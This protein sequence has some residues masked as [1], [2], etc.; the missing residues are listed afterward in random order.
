MWFITISFHPKKTAFP[1]LR[2]LYNHH[3]HAGYF[4]ALWTHLCSQLIHFLSYECHYLHFGI[5]LHSTYNPSTTPNIC[6]HTHTHT[7]TLAHPYTHTSHKH[8]YPHPSASSRFQSNPN[9][10]PLPPL[11]R[12][13]LMHPFSAADTHTIGGGVLWSKLWWIGRGVLWLKLVSS[14]QETSIATKYIA[15][16]VHEPQVK[17][18]AAEF[19]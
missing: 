8:L 11:P 12:P 13:T 17:G 6:T 7:H 16:T 4:F 14:D 19:F 9:C 1:G 10:S 18:T 3:V 15:I 2:R 5:T